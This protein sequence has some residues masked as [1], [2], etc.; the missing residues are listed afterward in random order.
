MNV[1]DVQLDTYYTRS[2]LMYVIA[3]YNWY[4]ITFLKFIS[5][6]LISKTGTLLSKSLSVIFSIIYIR[7]LL[8]K[9][10]IV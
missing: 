1:G 3:L 8:H 2:R 10:L 9:K 4:I 5:S 7:K 6:T